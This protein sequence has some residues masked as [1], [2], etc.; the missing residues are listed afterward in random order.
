MEI[1]CLQETKI[2]LNFPEESLN[3]GNFNAELETNDSKK[4]A[5]I[6][7]RRD[8]KYKRGKDLARKNFHVVIIDVYAL[9]NVRIILKCK[10]FYSR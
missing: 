10:S 8:V 7:K 1:C 3:C 4:R 9:K 5:G 2:P 6:H